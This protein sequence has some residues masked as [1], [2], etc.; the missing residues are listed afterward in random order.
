MKRVMLT[1]DTD[2]S[3]ER[4]I[5]MVQNNVMSVVVPP[6]SAEVFVADIVKKSI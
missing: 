4:N 3:T 1:T 2:Y 6:M 5:S